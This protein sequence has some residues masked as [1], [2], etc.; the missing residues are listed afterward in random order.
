[1]AEYGGE[2]Y[3]V[4]YET[5]PERYGEHIGQFEEVLSTFRFL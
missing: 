1:M 3:H 5:E 4:S 2:A